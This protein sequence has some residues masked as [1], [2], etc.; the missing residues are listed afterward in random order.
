MTR[1][2]LLAMTQS[3]VGREDRSLGDRLSHELPGILNWAIEGWKRL[4]NRGYFVQPGSAVE[5]LDDLE[6]LSSPIKQFIA[7]MCETGPTSEASVVT[8]FRAWERW[9][10]DNHRDHKGTNQTFGRDLRA[11]LPNLRQQN[12]RTVG[13]RRERWYIGIAVKTEIDW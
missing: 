6:N 9:C 1:V 12:R 11:G 3:F 10:E 2:V 8:L 4:N 5:M 13:D 7:D